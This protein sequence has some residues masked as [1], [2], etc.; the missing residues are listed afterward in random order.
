[1]IKEIFTELFEPDSDQIKMLK[2]ADATEQAFRESAP[3]FYNL[4]LATHGFFAQAEKKSA[5]TPD[6]NRLEQQRLYSER[7]RMIRGFS[8]GLLSGLVFSG[9]NRKPEL[10][11]DDGI[12]TA[13][14]IASLSLDGV[15][16]VVLS[17]CETGLGEVAGGEGLLGVQRAFQVA[18][19]SS[20]VASL[21]E[22]GDVATRRLMERFY[23]NYWQKEMGKLDALR[24]AQLYLLRHPEA[25]R[26][27][28]RVSA[29]SIELKRLS[30]QFWAAFQLSGD[31]R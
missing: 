5:L 15:N 24:E 12:L 4:H 11:K 1:M 31:W 29:K 8:P 18:G 30:P 13:D 9:A 28:S 25:V 26:G 7:D 19:A 21:W 27:D 17:A 16:L 3:Q 22:V 23:R 6:A 20:T 14:E 2:Q 10:N